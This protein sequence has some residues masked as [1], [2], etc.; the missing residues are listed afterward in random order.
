MAEHRWVFGSAPKKHVIFIGAGASASVGYPL[1]VQLKDSMCNPGAFRNA[2]HAA[3]SADGDGDKGFERHSVITEY[4]RLS[5]AAALLRDGGFNTMD[6]LSNF[7]LEGGHTKLIRQLKKLMRLILAIPNPHR[8]GAGQSDYEIAIPK[9]IGPSGLRDDIVIVSFN[10]DVFLDFKLVRA[11]AARSKLRPE[12]AK[13]SSYAL[14]ALASGFMN[15][16]DVSWLSE[17]GPC[18]LK[19]HGA[20]AF[21]AA[22]PDEG[23]A[24]P[25]QHDQNPRFS[26]AYLFN[27]PAMARLAA[28]CQSPFENQDPP[29]LLPWEIIH[30][31][32]NRLLTETEFA[33][34]VG[35]E[36]QPRTMY[37][38][39]SGL[40]TRAREEVQSAEGVSFVGLSLVSYLLPGLKFLFNGKKGDVQIVVANRS[41]Q[42]F[43]A[44]EL[45][46]SQKSPAG[47]TLR[48]LTEHCETDCRFFAS[49]KE[50][51]EVELEDFYLEKHEPTV[52][53]YSTF[54]DFAANEL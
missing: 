54:R 43:E 3:F 5:E 29:T 26:T 24:L 30:H 12:Y 53:C 41:M 37:K 13:R 46:L 28:L 31:N 36:W 18:H 40:W 52:T 32:E 34:V 49:H 38:L 15:P 14:Q 9:L 48:T 51:D 50:R 1:A 25:V 22:N 2:L 16:D 4:Q 45:Q 7:A 23:P 17:N 19:L 35:E 10:Y 39:F 47:H 8:Y 11:F 20:C 33:S 44:P 6:E 27:R 21:S 42:G